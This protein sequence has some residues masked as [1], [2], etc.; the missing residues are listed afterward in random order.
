[1][2]DKR[3][4]KTK[5]AIK[6]AFLDLLQYRP[7]D[8]ITVTELCE[9]ADVS[10]ITFYAHYADKI[11]LADEIC[12]DL[13]QLA[14]DDY[15]AMQKQNNPTGDPIQSYLNVLDSILNLYEQQ[16]FFRYASQTENPYLYYA[17]YQYVYRNVQH[18]IERESEAL[19]PKYN[20]HGVASFL[21]NGLWGFINE[22]LD[23]KVPYDR[24]RTES[25]ELLYNVLKS[26]VLTR[27]LV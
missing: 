7:F 21:C 15:H 16:E 23:R 11:E 9:K 18:R 25:R 22:C 12:G 14:R 1:M 24:V 2:E 26:E 13:L 19:K 10:R 6:R 27:N 5:K 3:I 17:F 8:G 4:R 20:F